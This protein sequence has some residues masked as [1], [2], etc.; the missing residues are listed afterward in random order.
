M[1]GLV[2]SPPSV[3]KLVSHE[4]RWNLLQLLAHSDYRVHDLVEQ[5]KLPQ[6]LGFVP[7]EA[8]SSGT[9]GHGTQK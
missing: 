5:L 6:N 1:D 8:A 3:L 4:V 7:L 9:P 2:V